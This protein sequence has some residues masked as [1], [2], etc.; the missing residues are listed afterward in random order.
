M[1]IP[2]QQLPPP[3]PPSGSQPARNASDGASG[4]DAQQRWPWSA[5]H[6][7]LVAALWIIGAVALAALS[8]AA[9]GSGAFPGDVGIEK[10]IQQLHQPI[11]VRIINFAS[12]ANW[13]QPAGVIAIVVIV[14]LAL[15]R[16][17]R[18]AIAAAVGSFGADFVNVALNGLVKRPRPYGNQIHAVAHLGLY[19]YPSGHVTHVLAFYG[20]L[21]YLSV[22]FA[23]KW[24]AARPLW[25]VARIICLYFILFIGPS[26]ILEGEHWPS[27]VLASYLLG[28]LML[29]VGIVVFHLLGM[30]WARIR[31][32]RQRGGERQ[33]HSPGAA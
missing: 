25:W 28:A 32:R 12:D 6:T 21:L 7:A 24:P 13:P 15:A 11:L 18:A 16:Q 33:A 1:T 9:R 10:W 17:M 19:S 2:S 20:F 23:R 14:A 8:V 31:E 4:A 29:V 26:R 30:A 3:F 27:D 5:G 22:I